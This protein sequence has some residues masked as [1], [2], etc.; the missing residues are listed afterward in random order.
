MKYIVIL[1]IG[2]VCFIWVVSNSEYVR[3]LHLAGPATLYIATNQGHAYHVALLDS[4]KQDWTEITHGEISGPIVCMDLLVDGAAV[5]GRAPNEDKKDAMVAF[6]NGSGIATAIGVRILGNK[7]TVIWQCKWLADRE[8]QL[9]G[10]FWCKSLGRR[11][12]FTTDPR[13][14]VRVWLLERCLEVQA[15]AEGQDSQ[16]QALLIANY[17]SSLQARIVCLDVCPLAELLVCGDQR[18]NLVLFNFPKT[19]LQS[20]TREGLGAPLQLQSVGVFKG[21]HGIS[22]VASVYVASSINSKDAVITSTGRDGC[23]CK[24]LVDTV[25]IKDNGESTSQSFACTGVEDVSAITVV[26]SVERRQDQR[27]CNRR[28]AAGFIAS[29]FILWD[30]TQQ[31]ELMRVACGGWRRPHS[32]VVGDIPEHQCCFAFLKDHIIHVHRNWANVPL[33]PDS[34]DITKDDNPN[35]IQKLISQLPQSLHGQFHGREIHSVQFVPAGNTS[36]SSDQH[37]RKW[38]ATGSEDGAVRISRYDAGMVTNL[39]SFLMLGE[40]TGGSAVRALTLVQG[41]QTYVHYEP[42]SIRNLDVSMKDPILL[43]SVGAKEVLTC[44]LLE[45]KQEPNSGSAS[46]DE[47]EMIGTVSED[48]VQ[49][50]LVTEVL[51]SRWLCSYSPPRTF[52][53]R[54]KEKTASKVYDKQHVD[55]SA[56]VE[57]TQKK[58]KQLTGGSTVGANDV[59]DLRFLAVTAL[60][61]YS[62]DI[63]SVFC[64]VVTASSNAILKLLGMNLTTRTWVEVAVLEH[65]TVPVLALQHLVVPME[66]G[67]QN[68]YLII[69][70]ATD[71][72]IAV[73]DI[74]S[75]VV[76]FTRQMVSGMQSLTSS[77]GIQLRPRTGRGSQGGR[78][79]RSKKQ[80]QAGLSRDKKNLEASKNVVEREFDVVSPNNDVAKEKLNTT[81]GAVADSKADIGAAVPV[82]DLS[83]ATESF[84]YQSSVLYPLCTFTEAHQ[85]GVNC[86][87]AAT[88]IGKRDSEVVVVSGGDDQSLHVLRFEL[89]EEKLHECAPTKG[90]SGDDVNVSA[91][92]SAESLLAR[93]DSAPKVQL[94]INSTYRV[95]VHGAHSS[96]VKGIWTDGAWV[97][98]TGLDQRLRCWRLSDIATYCESSTAFRDTED[99]IDKSLSSSPSLLECYLCVIDVPEAESLHVES[100]PI[101]GQYCISVVGRGLQVFTFATKT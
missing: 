51:S 61:V 20:H 26:E 3:C 82:E 37:L 79:S 76:T 15:S 25:T 38:I 55:A 14:L 32:Y 22:P 89:I 11:F 5:V 86:L 33:L 99:S 36:M 19:F 93:G 52:K 95:S 53:L 31:S 90:S 94:A 21:A 80:R 67:R 42:P 23:I 56:E 73:W 97:F 85:S 63:R 96:A 49:Q 16:I 75:L 87:S 24:F 50:N 7:P 12:A 17:Q 77:T 57:D 68:M 39:E 60:S 47:V 88:V 58:L 46:V 54:R 66:G 28:L 101:R 40:H 83:K 30:L 84:T 92:S 81:E 72:S 4:A 64:F 8:R 43:L 35:S 9:L 6:G 44:W 62:L 74:T 78:R 27:K 100:V 41:A 1:I 65:H 29:N 71:G 91:T 10:V 59:D 45:W 69:S 48:D 98:S 18:G 70:G 34:M 13:G 2:E